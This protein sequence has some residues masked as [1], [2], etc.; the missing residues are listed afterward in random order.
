MSLDNIV[1][2]QLRNELLVQ[3]QQLKE[4]LN[5]IGYLT[6]FIKKERGVYEDPD[7]FISV[8]TSNGYMPHEIRKMSGEEFFIKVLE[9]MGVRYVVRAER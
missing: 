6:D 2:K 5:K 7:P 1:Y 9:P 4:I 8:I 3:R